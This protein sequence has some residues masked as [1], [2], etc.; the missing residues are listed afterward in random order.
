MARQ[1]MAWHGMALPHH[2]MDCLVESDMHPG[3]SHTHPDQPSHPGCT[4]HAVAWGL[5]AVTRAAAVVPPPPPSTSHT[6]YQPLHMTNPF[7]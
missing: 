7:T 6:C 5:L 2:I 1:G 3:E 4:C